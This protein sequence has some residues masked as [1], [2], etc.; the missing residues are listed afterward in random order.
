M[1]G[2]VDPPEGPSLLSIPLPAFSFL[3]KIDALVRRISW[4]N[5]QHPDEKSL[6]FSQWK[7]ALGLVSK[8][9]TQS[10]I[11]HT[12]LSG[13]GGVKGGMQAKLALESFNQDEECKVML[14]SLQTQAAGLTLVR[15]SR[16][17]LLE[18]A[19]DASIE[20]QA[21]A[22]VHRVGQER[23]TVITRLI[24]QGTIEEKVLAK[25]E[26]KQ[27]ILA[28]GGQGARR[29]EEGEVDEGGDEMAMVLTSKAPVLR[30]E[31]VNEGDA[32]GLLASLLDE[33]IIQDV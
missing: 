24:V 19:L 12:S 20:Q 14:L 22:R 11:K 8:A 28:M 1:Y 9:L 30:N 16:V 5:I 15:A 29:G 6:I 7:E 32:R 10:G 17:F 2:E 3:T 27:R 31:M 18:P 4:L 25:L 33:I 13:G 26:A 21:V 23:E